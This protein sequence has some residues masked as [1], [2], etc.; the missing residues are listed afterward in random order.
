M[1][2]IIRSTPA[3]NNKLNAKVVIPW[4]YLSSF[5]WSLSLPWLN[6]EIELDSSLSRNYIIFK[7]SR[8]AE[9]AANPPNASRSRTKTAG[10]KFHVFSGKLYVPVVTLSV[11]NNIKFLENERQGFKR[12][13]SWKNYTSKVTTQP[14]NNLDYMINP[15]FRNINSLFVIF[16][17]NGGNDIKRDSFDRYYILLVKTKSLI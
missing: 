1:T 4:K 9:V 13:V 10:A 12:T 3:N 11:N 2:K 16:F 15:T 5:C 8:T 14:K 7:I 6:C 17:K